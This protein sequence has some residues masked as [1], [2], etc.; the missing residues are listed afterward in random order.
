MML[1]HCVIFPV[2]VANPQIVLEIF[3]VLLAHHA[4]LVLPF[5]AA[6][7]GTKQRLPAPY[8]V[9]MACVLMESNV[10]A[11]LHV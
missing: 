1:H 5:S 3:S 7:H 4:K 2:Q 8:R 11:S 10:L 9:K 6:R